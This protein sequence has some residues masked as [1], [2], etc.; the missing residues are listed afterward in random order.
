MSG[1][2]DLAI[3]GAGPCGLAAGVAAR[4]AGLRAELFDAGNVVASIA[5]Y[6]IHTVFFSTAEKIAIG[7]IPFEP[8]G[9]RPTRTAALAYYRDVVTRAGLTVRAYEPVERIERL[10]DAPAAPGRAARFL[11]HSRTAAGART[12]PAHAV[13]LATGYFGSPRR[14][15]VPGESLPHVTHEFREGH[16]AF[17]R[18][19]LVVGGGNSAVEAAIELADCGAQVTLVHFGPDFDRNIKPWIRPSLDQAVAAGSVVLRWQARV[20]AIHAGTVE[21]DTAE[22]VATLA[23]DHVY[24]MTG[25]EPSSALATPLGVTFDPA[26][27]VPAHDPATMETN[28]PGV[29]VA[30]VLVSG[31]DANRIFIENGRDHGTL[32]AQAVAGR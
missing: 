5:R 20:R 8:A 22:G 19:A 9:T 29:Y 31:L 28:V 14:L 4:A 3:V 2:L 1:A 10:P 17:G 21:L 16:E 12:T 30:G 13:V 18:R 7:G 24:V 23:A 25:Y 32:I 15:G 27:R 11:V 6:P 26:T